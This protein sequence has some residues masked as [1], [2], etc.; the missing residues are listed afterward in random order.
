MTKKMRIANH[1]TREG[2]SESSSCSEST[3]NR[4]PPNVPPF[5]T[6]SSPSASQSASHQCSVDN[7]HRSNATL[8]APNRHLGPMSSR[9]LFRTMPS[10]TSLQATSYQCNINENRSYVM[11]TAPN[12]HSGPTS[13]RELFGLNV[14]VYICQTVIW[15]HS[16]RFHYILIIQAFEKYVVGCLDE[17]KTS[18]LQHDTRLRQLESRFSSARGEEMPQEC[19]VR[20]PLNEIA[21]VESFNEYLST[22]QN[23]KNLVSQKRI[24]DLLAI[25]S[26]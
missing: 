22:P 5:P 17:I 13:A 8:T 15:D 3:E 21:G 2:E 23:R 19:P 4:P 20:L 6:T 16:I 24:T 25:V 26:Y 7:E 18:Q 10:S 1:K 14:S 11:P 12:R 9:E